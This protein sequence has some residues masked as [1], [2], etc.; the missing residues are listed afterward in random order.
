MSNKD[1]VPGFDD[2]TKRGWEKGIDIRLQKVDEDPGCLVLYLTGYIDPHNANYFMRKVAKAIE[3]GFT[4]L[5]FHLAGFNM[6]SDVIVGS[7]VAFLKAVQPRG[8][9]IVLTET[10]SCFVERPS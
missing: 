4:R 5:I 3:S 8:G 1:I 2:K 9:D 10:R 6:V 7:L